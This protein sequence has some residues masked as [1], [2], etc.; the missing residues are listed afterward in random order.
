MEIH[1][2]SI[3]GFENYKVNL[4]GQV[5]NANT[6]NYLKKYSGG[7]ITLSRP[8]ERKH[9]QVVKL[10]EKLFVKKSW[11]KKLLNIS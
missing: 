9:V 2:K 6:G 11:W 10:V 5:F 4:S 3:P 7:Y 8:G 1:W